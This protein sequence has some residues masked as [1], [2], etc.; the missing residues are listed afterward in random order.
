MSATLK[1]ASSGEEIAAC[2]RQRFE[3]YTEE[4]NLYRADA[5]HAERSLSD[6]F[7]AWARFFYAEVDGEVVASMRMHWGCDGVAKAGLAKGFPADWCEI[8]RFAEFAEVPVGA[9]AV[10]SK[11]T[12]DQAFRGGALPT[13]LIFYSIEQ[14]M[15][16]GIQLLFLDCVPHLINFYA[17][18]GWRQYTDNI[19]DSDVGILVPMC[20]V[21]DDVEHLQR[22]QSP[23]LKVVQGVRPAAQTPAW[24]NTKFPHASYAQAGDLDPEHAAVFA[25]LSQDRLAIF[26][27]LEPAQVNT[28]IANGNVLEC[29]ADT[30]FIR[31]RTVYRSV[32]VVLSGAMQV[33][34]QVA[35]GSAKVLSELE[36]GELV[37][38]VSFV[39][40]GMRT[41]DVYAG[42]QGATV[43][44]LQENALRKVLKNEAPIAALFY[45][46]LAKILALRLSDSVSRH[47]SPEQ[48]HA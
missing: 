43:L 42:P 19:E 48:P 3:I 14:A 39:L 12:A 11:L 44:A 9:M 40:G 41:A 33:R 30:L 28:L 22:L 36:A 7:D 18:L 46:N 2:V 21:F 20:L 38:E 23:L 10:G 31:R 8:Y 32:F 37:G 34:A 17:R 24:V 45:H 47:S 27:G 16:A 26:Q 13:R 4:M 15:R 29:E 6:P 1:C 35:G 5:N 25:L